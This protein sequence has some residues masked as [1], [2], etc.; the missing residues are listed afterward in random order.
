MSAFRYSPYTGDKTPFS[1]GLAPIDPAE[2]IETDRNLCRYLAEKDRLLAEDRERVFRAK[3]ETIDA[4]QETLELVT[5]FLPR[6]YPDLYRETASGIEIV[7]AGN[8]VGIAGFSDRPLE[9]AA[10]LVQDDLVLMR[11][12]EKGYELVAACVCFPSSW[13]LAEK[14]GRSLDAIHE[15][16][17]GYAGRMARRMNLIFD[18]LPASQIV[19]RTNWSIYGNDSLASFRSGNEFGGTEG[20]FDFDG[21]Y[22]RVE[23]QT[24]RRLPRSGDIL[25]TIMIYLDPLTRLRNHPDRAALAG[26]LRRQVLALNDGELAYKSLTDGQQRLADYLARIADGSE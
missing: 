21:A 25:F 5:E 24:L 9:A 26:G 15:P 3:P 10:R 6:R 17:P 20:G 4:Q 13:S 22:V 8:I 12:G 2:W 11:R 18:R 7:S 16:V 19:W 1:I 23:R 14:F